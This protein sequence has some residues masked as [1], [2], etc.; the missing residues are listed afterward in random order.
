M[1]TG[2]RF[3]PTKC[4]KRGVKYGGIIELL[5]ADNGCPFLIGYMYKSK[6]G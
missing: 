2:S 1:L 5:A 6:A 3:L 4:R